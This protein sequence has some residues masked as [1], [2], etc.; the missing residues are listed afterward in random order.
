[1]KLMTSIISFIEHN[2]EEIL[3]FKLI[4]LM[5][6]KLRYIVIYCILHPCLI[7]VAAHLAESQSSD[8]YTLPIVNE[9]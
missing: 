2:L 7:I 8:P 9:T 6:K 1:M 4:Q 5:R 3:N